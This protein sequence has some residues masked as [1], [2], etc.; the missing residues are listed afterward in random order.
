[1]IFRLNIT[2]TVFLTV[3]L[4][5]FG[6]ALNQLAEAQDSEPLTDQMR[7]LLKSE[8]FNVNFLLQSEAAFT[9]KDDDFLGG[10]GFGLGSTR[11]QF[12]G[13][14]DGGYSYEMELELRNS[15][16]VVDA[17][18]GYKS[19]DSFAIKV[20]MQKP[21]IGL[22]LQPGPGK[23]DFIDRARFIGLILNRR[24]IGI[25]ALGKVDKF[26]YMVAVYNGTGLSLENE[27]NLMYVA[28]GAFTFEQSNSGR[29]YV[30]AN[31]A[32]NGTEGE[33]IGGLRSEGDRL[34]YGAFIDYRSK[35]WLGAAEVLMTS[36]ESFAQ[37][38]DETITGA[39]VT[40]GNNITEKDQLLA[41][42]EHIGFDV[43][44]TNSNLYIFGWNHQATSVISFQVNALAQI[45]DNE[46]YFGVL[47]NFQYEF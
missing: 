36:F 2:V 13:E 21:D 30:G 12:D 7:D 6:T 17:N 43:Q 31:G 20:G 37:Q 24:E 4:L 38:Q 27:G 35:N 3:L 1:M 14:V 28:K 8:P 46:E 41:R 26:D 42:M 16:S 23:T 45:D 19:S 44:D 39:Y 9:F 47:G 40:I 15:P 25:T 29:L 5:T 33:N 22:D 11:L 18:V 34:I 32:I 10:N